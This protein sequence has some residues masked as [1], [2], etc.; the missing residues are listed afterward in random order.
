ML[1]SVLLPAACAVAAFLIATKHMPRVRGFAMSVACLLSSTT[2]DDFGGV[3]P[4]NR[5]MLYCV[6]VALVGCIG[7]LVGDPKSRR[8]HQLAMCVVAG[9]VAA[10]VFALPE[11]S[12][13]FSRILLAV[14]TSLVAAI[15]IPLGSHRAGF[16]WWCSMGLSF[17]AV[18]AIALLCGFA[19]LSFAVASMFATCG[20]LSLATL[21]V[22]PRHTLCGG[23]PGTLV[24]AFGVV[25]G[26]AGAYAYDTSGMPR[27]VFV[28]AALSPTGAW[29]AE[30][31]A[32]R[33]S[34]MTSALARVAGVLILT[35]LAVG[36]AVAHF[37][38]SEPTQ[39]AY[40][41]RGDAAPLNNFVSR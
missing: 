6:A 33:Q 21:V 4:T 41:Y 2:L 11:W 32:F 39:D 23:V 37:I 1:T 27:W 24:I 36:G 29:L 8:V 40:A 14:A 19:K 13:I 26:A 35:G 18:A 34:A 5:W 30:A 31:Q 12:G 22:S 28:I 25:L 9:C 38:S 10:S 16:S 15:L 7:A 20:L 3:P 17:A